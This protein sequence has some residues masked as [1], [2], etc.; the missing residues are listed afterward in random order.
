MCQ[1]GHSGKKKLMPR[2]KWWAER[3]KSISPFLC[4]L[5]RVIQ[6]RSILEG[7]IKS[8]LHMPGGPF[9]KK[10]IDAAKKVVGRKAEKH[11][12]ISLLFVQGHSEQEH[13]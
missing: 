12:S 1:V 5:F 7:Q 13:N 9:R 6:N 11:F 2:R 3:H 4:F 8:L 10:E